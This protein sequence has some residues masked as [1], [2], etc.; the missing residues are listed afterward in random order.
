MIHITLNLIVNTTENGSLSEIRPPADTK[1]KVAA[2]GLG[3]PDEGRR[4]GEKDE[5]VERRHVERVMQVLRSLHLEI[6][7]ESL[8]SGAARAAD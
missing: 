2:A 6:P 5:E 3:S 7:E 1:S 8:D 4:R